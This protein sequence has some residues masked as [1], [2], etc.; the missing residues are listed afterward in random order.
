MAWRPLIFTT[1]LLI[2]QVYT[3]DQVDRLLTLTH[4]TATQEVVTLSQNVYNEIGQSL[5][6]KLHQSPSHPN[7]LQKLDMSYNIRGWLNGV[8]HPVVTDTAYE[9]KDLFNLS[10]HY[11]T[12]TMPGASTQYNGNIAE[13]IL[14]NGYD[15][16]ETGY[17][18]Q[19]DQ[20][21]RLISSAWGA[22]KGA[23]WS[24]ANGFNES[25]ISYD[26]N[27]NILTLNRYMGSWNNIDSLKYQNYTGNQLG[28]VSDLAPVNMTTTG[29]QDKD[30]GTGSDYLYDLNG[31]MTSDYNKSISSI[32]YNFLNLPNVISITGKGTITYTYDATGSKLQKTILDTTVHPNK[33]TNYY[34]AGNFV[35]RNDTLESVSHP[36]GRLRPVRI[37]TTQAISIANL[38]YIYDY[39]LKDHLGS[40]RSVLTTEQQTDIYA[41]TMETANAAKENAL[42][43]NVSA[44]AVNKPAGMTND[45]NNQKV[46]KLNGAVNISGNKRVGPS[47]I[48]KVMTGDT[49]SIST[50]SWYT[51]SVQP[52]ATGVTSI[53]NDLLP[54]LTA[55]V[56]GANGGKGGAVPTSFSGPL[57]GTDISTLLSNDSNTY[58]S[59]RPKAFLNWMVVGEDY[60]AATNS[61]N[62]V[63]AVQIPV[64]N[65]GDTMKLI[66]GLN[67]MVIRRNGWIYIYLSNESAQDV[68][69]DNL[70]IN[71]KHGP[72]V[73]QKDYYAFGMEN[74]V[75]STQSIKTPYFANRLRYNGKEIQDKEFSTGFGLTWNDYGARMY[76][77]QTCRWLIE[78]PLSEK[79]R[80]FTPYNYVV[81]NPIR[82]IDPDG[83]E[84]QS[85]GQTMQNYGPGDA[86]PP[87]YMQ[88]GHVINPKVG[89][90]NIKKEAIQAQKNASS[91]S[92]STS[93]SSSSTS[94]SSQADCPT[95]P[96][97]QYL[98]EFTD[99]VL[100]DLTVTRMF[101]KWLIGTPVIGDFQTDE[102]FIN[103]RVTDE[104]R[105]SPG[106]NKAR[107]D[108]YKTGKTSGVYDFGAAAFIG[109][110]LSP[111]QQFVGG[112]TYTITMEGNNLKF[113]L[114]NVTSISSADYHITIKD[115]DPPFGV[116]ANFTQTYIFT[117]QIKK[118]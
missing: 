91:S 76:D 82:Y 90:E 8:N 22:F 78:D 111:I 115:D 29:F 46:S 100:N 51:G 5:N 17:T 107:D 34:Y 112:Y 45:N 61:Q 15:E 86:P 97:R 19:Y 92:G 88:D 89:A 101:L 117:E 49:I 16:A 104:M 25:G 47:I 2:K 39:F 11:S 54:L 85:Y 27:G 103:D 52:A 20:T 65:S 30:N 10:L 64:C 9:E 102:T 53:A 37:D 28:K 77:P 43:S 58:V 4:Q 36:E 80:R 38:K 113:T 118:K 31:N 23:S 6:K 69:F 7:S 35:Y 79:N 40:V 33:T 44:T 74:A 105:N 84:Y 81:N 73:E 68:Y 109:A 12:A 66:V 59:T 32:T 48:L 62:H 75:L 14:K 41:A 70:A 72:L 93:T 3:Y 106:V 21:N 18:F 99:G 56:A 67:S 24:Q 1:P 63:S 110:G 13:E 50:N 116:M 60:V 71:L 57:L 87:I 95:C 98:K 26:H 42:F 83:M 96:K 94:S 108:F 55:G 114:T